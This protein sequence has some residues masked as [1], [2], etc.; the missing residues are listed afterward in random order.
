[1]A[2]STEFKVNIVIT[3]KDRTSRETDKASK[4]LIALQK[5]AKLATVGFA[6]LKTAQAGIRFAKLG[7]AVQRQAKSLDALAKSAGS[8]GEEIVSAMQGASDFTIDR[9]TA[10]QAANKAMLL[11]VA[12]SPAEFERLTKVATALGRVMGQDAA[13][14]IDD[15][16]TAAG[17][18][19]K[20]IADNLGL[21]VGAA[22]ANKRYADSLGITSDQLTDAQKKQAFLTEMLRQGEIKMAAMGK[23]SLDTAGKMEQLES[24]LSDLKTGFAEIV[25]ED[26]ALVLET[27]R[28][29]ETVRTLP[30]VFRD[31]RNELQT[32]GKLHRRTADEYAELAASGE[33]FQDR[34][35]KIRDAEFLINSVLGKNVERWNQYSNAL[36]ESE[37]A[38]DAAAIAAVDLRGKQT[39]LALDLGNSSLAFDQYQTAVNESMLAQNNAAI[40]AV[41]LRI[42]ED[43]LRIATENVTLAQL[44]LS[45]QL[46][47]AS[48][49]QIAQAA[50]TELKTQLDAGKITFDQYKTAVSETQLAFG[51]TTPASIA[52]ASGIQDL[53]ADLAS[54]KLDAAGFN[55]A[56]TNLKISI[57][58]IPTSK[59]VDIRINVRRTGFGGSLGTGGDATVEQAAAAAA[60]AAGPGVGFAGPRPGEGGPGFQRGADFTVPPGFDDDFPMR[61]SSG[62]RVIVIPRSQNTTNN[63]TLNSSTRATQPAVDQNF[64]MMQEMAA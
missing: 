30:E 2:G 64:Q 24:A 41:D 33:R 50:I 51:L 10:M 62:E 39:L 5:A 59:T 22:D 3:S 63:F 17:R 21:M 23:T 12:K 60:A 15:F 52:L 46:K 36:I 26:V 8:S 31:W 49:A 14:S 13:K 48:S 42:A 25:A 20:M 47:D 53:A 18:Q 19:S 16:V 43:E 34:Q 55:E 45:A 61:V 27:E 11:D 58:Q 54:G 29:A 32:T 44:D 4:S 38:S 37:G 57:D 28:L 9:M 6:A 7:A 35:E 1:M 40:S 56:L